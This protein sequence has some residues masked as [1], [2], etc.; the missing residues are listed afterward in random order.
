MNSVDELKKQKE[1]YVN[2]IF[3]LC[4]EMIYVFLIPAVIAAFAGVSLD[5]IYSTGRKI[6]VVFLAISFIFS[7]TL[8]I[9]KY[10]KLNKELKEINKAIKDKK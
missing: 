9:V 1:R 6:T 8:I 4:I 7:W 2:K 10:I 3:F 5:N